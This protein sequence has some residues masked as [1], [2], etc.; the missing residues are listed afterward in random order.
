[1]LLDDKKT[2]PCRIQK[3]GPCVYE[4]IIH[5]GRKRQIRRMFAA[6][7]YYV[8]DLCRIR[9]GILVLGDLKPGDFRP[10]TKEEVARLKRE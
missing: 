4:M 8:R 7:R 2:A 6:L 5:E 10:L 9:Q 3:S 1:M